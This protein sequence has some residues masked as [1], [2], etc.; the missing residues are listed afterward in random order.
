MKK[1]TI[2]LNGERTGIPEGS[3]VAELLDLA[4]AEGQRIAVVVNEAVIRPGDRSAT[5]LKENDQV[6]LLVFAGGG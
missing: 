1:I 3:T 4:G 2:I 5:I 6:D